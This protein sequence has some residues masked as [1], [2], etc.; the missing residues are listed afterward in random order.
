MNIINYIITI[1]VYHN[2]ISSIHMLAIWAA[3]I[4]ESLSVCILISFK[5]WNPPC[6]FEVTYK[7]FTL[8]AGFSELLGINWSGATC[9]VCYLYCSGGINWGCSYT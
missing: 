8:F 9:C 6:A 5:C 2:R 3:V 4:V 7:R 1:Q